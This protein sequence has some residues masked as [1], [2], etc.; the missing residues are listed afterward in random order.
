MTMSIQLEL[1]AEAQL[2]VVRISGPFSVA[3][4]KQR[5]LEV[6]EAVAQHRVRKVL[7]DGRTLVGGPTMM[8]RFF[9]AEHAALSI[10]KYGVPL[11][12]QFAY[13]L[14]QPV[15]DPERFG[16]NVAVNRGMLTRTFE[17][18]EDALAWLDIGSTDV[19][20]LADG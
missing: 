15:R 12:T 8:E 9:Y 1:S 18:I 4:A 13:V 7:I 11:N 16:E 3:E 6:L 19:P 14:K 20:D 10:A 2:L 5:F 17:S